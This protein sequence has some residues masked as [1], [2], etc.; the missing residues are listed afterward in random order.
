MHPCAL[1]LRHPETHVLK[2]RLLPR[3]VGQDARIGFAAAAKVSGQGRSVSGHLHFRLAAPVQGW[4]LAGLVAFQN[5]STLTSQT[6]LHERIQPR[7]F[8]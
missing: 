6:H 3:P 1:P 8:G 7:L 5:I 2:M 4:L